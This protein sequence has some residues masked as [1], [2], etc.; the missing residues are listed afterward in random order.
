MF[1]VAHRIAVFSERL[2]RRAHSPRLLSATDQRGSQAAKRAGALTRPLASSADHRGEETSNRHPMMSLVVSTAISID[3]DGA[4]ADSLIDKQ[5]QLGASQARDCLKAAFRATANKTDRMHRYADCLKST[6]SPI[7][8]STDQEK[9]VDS[10]LFIAG[11]YILKR[12]FGEI[13]RKS[14]GVLGTGQFNEID[15]GYK[16]ALVI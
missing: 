12:E 7:D 14:Y 5:I 6:A 13:D 2:A 15:A 1:G 8:Y 3:L 10:G 9:V 16:W 4:S 11:R